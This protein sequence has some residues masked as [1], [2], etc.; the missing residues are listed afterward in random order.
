MGA[1]IHFVHSQTGILV[2]RSKMTTWDLRPAFPKT[3]VDD[4]TAAWNSKGFCALL[5]PIAGTQSAI[6]SLRE[7]Y[8]IAFLTTPLKTNP[9]W[10][11]E[12]LQWLMTFYEAG[13]NDVVFSKKKV[14]YVKEFD[15]L[16]DDKY[17]NV[18]EW[19]EAGGKA[20]LIS[21]AHNA[22]KKCYR[23]ASDLCEAAYNLR[24]DI[25]HVIKAT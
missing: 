7:H 11:A 25:R 8:D 21:Q 19:T 24:R 12:R 9:H 20:I 13:R 17:E 1:S 16:I 10:E 2:P 6:K 22:G 5:N 15:W 23:R 4:L 18:T 3:I 14:D